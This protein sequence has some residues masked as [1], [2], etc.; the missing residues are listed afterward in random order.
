M[1]QIESGSERERERRQ[2]GNTCAGVRRARTG[3]HGDGCVGVVAMVAV[4]LPV[5]HANPRS[6]GDVGG[7]GLRTINLVRRAGRSPILYIAQRQGPTV[8][9]RTDAPDQGARQG[10]GRAVGLV[11][12]EINL[13]V[14]RKENVI[15]QNIAARHPLLSGHLRFRPSDEGFQS[16]LAVQL[17]FCLAHLF[18]SAWCSL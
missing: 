2:R 4:V 10:V 8:H 15:H 7:G 16:I 5:A 18:Y 6:I 17:T 11:P 12:L 9:E 14:L 3:G 1:R 13:T